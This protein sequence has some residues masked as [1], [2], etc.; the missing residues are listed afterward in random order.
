MA[1][2]RANPVT[3]LVAFYDGVTTS[4]DKGK[5]MDVVYLDLY[6]TFDMVPHNIL[7][8]KL[9]RYG[10]D[11]WTVWWMRNWRDGCIQRV[12]FNGTICGWTLVRSG[13]PHGSILGP[14]IFN[15][16]INVIDSGIK[17]SL[18]KS[19]DDTKL[20]GAVDMPGGQDVIQRDLDKLE[21][22]AQVNLMR[23][24]KAKCKALYLGQGNPRYQYRLEDEE[25]ESSPVEKDSGGYYWMKDWT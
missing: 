16:F 12:V 25:I 5:A 7:L 18:S 1:S 17:C 9:E 19:A 23:S 20:S 13:V 8:S 2:P 24:N 14:V 10:L 11:G 3:Y 6:K 4:V 15:I 22:W 21:K